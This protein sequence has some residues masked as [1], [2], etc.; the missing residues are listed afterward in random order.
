LNS[1]ILIVLLDKDTNLR[2]TCTVKIQ[3][4]DDI[5]QRK[6]Q[7]KHLAY[8]GLAHLGELD[9]LGASPPRDV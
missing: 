1:T 4:N 8:I 7:A 5:K 6:K 9:T 3:T 2:L